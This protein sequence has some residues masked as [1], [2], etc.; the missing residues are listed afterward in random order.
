M[1]K[2][3]LSVVAISMVALIAVAGV[4]AYGF[5][6]NFGDLTDEEKTEMQEQRQD[7]RTA[8]ENDDYA[9]WEALMQE[10]LAEM[11]GKISEENFQQI[12]E[13]HSEMI[14][15]KE[16]IQEAIES[17]EI[18]KNPESIQTFLEENG[19]E[20]PGKGFGKMKGFRMEGEMGSHSCPFADSE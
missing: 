2:V 11:D 6:G 19:Y 15:I 17:G 18:E 10:R 13:R 1:N 7:M 5:G 12:R 20:L 14:E 3:L 16:L 9:N 8:I 4:T